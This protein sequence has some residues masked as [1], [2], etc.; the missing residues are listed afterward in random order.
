MKA[1]ITRPAAVPA[2][3]PGLRIAGY[4]SLFNRTDGGGDV[5]AKGA[6]RNA[7]GR[8][9]AAGI[10][11]LWQ[12]DPSRP[13]GIW[14]RV[15]EDQLGLHVAGRLLTGLDLGREA[16]LLITAGA[17]DGLSIGFRAVRAQKMAGG[18]LRRL[19]EIDLWEVSLVT[20]PLLDAARLKPVPSLS[21][22]ATGDA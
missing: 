15:E 1:G 13:I 10:R 16:A 14:D 11:M 4:A 17:L 3:G 20:F 19:A 8:K 7:L 9:G 6:F 18:S 22:S 5:V 12:H 21:S 2:G